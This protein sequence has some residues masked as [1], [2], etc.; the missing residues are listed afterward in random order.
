MDEP[1]EREYRL[2]IATGLMLH[3]VEWGDP[4]GR[5]LVILHG[6]AHDASHWA[7]VCRHLSQSF[8]CIVPDQRGHGSSD[9]A[10]DGDYSCQAQVADLRAL[11]EALELER[12]ALV[13][14]SMGGLNAL[15]FAGSWPERVTAL[16]LV[17]V[18]AGSRKAGLAAIARGARGREV[19]S[20]SPPVGF[21]P[22][23]LDF[24]PEYGGDGE[25]R[26]RLLEVSTAPMLM[27]RGEKSR[28]C[29]AEV[30]E[31]SARWGRGRV[32]TIPDAG[33]NVANH[34]APAVAEALDDFLKVSLA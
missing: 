34:N 2:E 33:H 31:E 14:H 13:G 12:F 10:P 6:G 22:R 29:S 28:I 7:A 19:A 32:V 17:D 4:A 21:D 23:L 18:A 16:V 3:V 25:E 24:V 30:A 1:R 11:S 26:T 27:I 20:D 9:R 8:R 15:H 5:P